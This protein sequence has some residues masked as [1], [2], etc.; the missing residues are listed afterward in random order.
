MDSTV[1]GTTRSYPTTSALPDEIESA[2]VWG[3][4]HF[5]FSTYAGAQ[6]GVQVADWA[7]AH[8]FGPR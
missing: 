6:L 8:Y 3:G 7:W 1:T 2:R 4:M 5:R